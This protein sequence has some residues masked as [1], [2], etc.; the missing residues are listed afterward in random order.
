[1]AQDDQVQASLDVGGDTDPATD[2]DDIQTVVVGTKRKRVGS[3]GPT[4]KYGFTS[5]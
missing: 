1:M 2:T 5:V 4:P 3:T